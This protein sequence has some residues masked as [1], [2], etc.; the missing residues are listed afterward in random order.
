MLETTTIESLLARRNARRSGEKKNHEKA[1][2]RALE[3]KFLAENFL[4]FDQLRAHLYHPCHFPTLEARSETRAMTHRLEALGWIERTGVKTWSVSA[5]PEIRSY[6]S[7]GWLEE[8]AFLAH[9]AAGADEIYFGQEIEWRVG[10]VVGKNEIDVIARR[11]DVLSFTSCKTIQADKTQG[12]MAQLRG[13]VTETDYWNI[14][15]ADDKGR[16][17]LVVTADFIDELNGNTHRYPQ[18]MA[19]AS[20][21]NVTVAGLESLAWPRLVESIKAHWQ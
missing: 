6:L 4:C 10:D 11:G 19:R 20:I 7:G 2:K 9:E 8:Y 12:H 15:F 14:H 5:N 3:T 13:F 1:R 21:L 16:A 18:L 17:L